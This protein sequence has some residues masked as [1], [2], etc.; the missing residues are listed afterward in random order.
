[1]RTKAF[2]GGAALAVASLSSSYALAGDEPAVPAATAMPGGR[3]MMDS[4]CPMKVQG[5]AVKARNVDGGVALVFTTKTGDVEDVRQ[6]V[7]HMAQMHGTNAAGMATTT[8]VSGVN[9]TPA[10]VRIRREPLPA[11]T[12][13]AEDVERGARLVLRP[14]DPAQLPRLR[15]QVRTLAESMAHLHGECPEMAVTVEAAPSAP[16]RAEGSA[17][18]PAPKGQ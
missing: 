11:S 1:M 4:M 12:A 8:T 3:E 7:R 9:R 15:R 16:G 18:Q 17:Q 5:T 10:E 13:S 6:R 2:I 14:K